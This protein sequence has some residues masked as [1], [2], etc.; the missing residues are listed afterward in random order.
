MP[1]IP[2]S[3]ERDFKGYL[4]VNSCGKQWIDNNHD[5]IRE[6]GRIDYSIQ[7]VLKGSGHYEY[8]NKITIIPEGSLVLYSPNE[9][10][11]SYYKKR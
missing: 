10:P 1:R 5:Q 2:F 4:R 8:N 9:R 3:T 11:P 6:N 7:Y